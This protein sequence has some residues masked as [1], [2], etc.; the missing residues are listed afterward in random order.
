MQS[1]NQ[2]VEYL[3]ALMSVFTIQ[4]NSSVDIEKLLMF[5]GKNWKQG[6]FNWKL[7]MKVFLSY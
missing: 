3:I 4:Y 2:L 1:V 5:T 7:F 6:D